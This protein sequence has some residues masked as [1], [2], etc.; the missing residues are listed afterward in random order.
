MASANT[1][2]LALLVADTDETQRYVFE[3]N[4][5]P[6]IRGASRLLFD[7]NQQCED[8]VTQ[9]SGEVIYAGGGSLL[10]LVPN[11]QG[12]QIAT[13]IEQLYPTQ[14][15]VATITAAVRPLPPSYQEKAFGQ[16]V[17]WATSWLTRRKES[18]SAPP[19]WAAMPFTV[20]CL[21]CMKRPTDPQYITDNFPDPICAICF[22]KREASQRNIWID[23]FES[24]LRALDHQN[25][26]ER[27]YGAQ[28]ANHIQSTYTLN[29]ISAANRARKGYVA[30][31][32][33]DGDRIGRQLRDLPRKAYRNFSRTLRQA[34]REAVFSALA[35]HLKPTQVPLS[36]L[37]P[38]SHN[39]KNSTAVVHPF[40]IITIGGDDVLLIVPADAGIPVATS[41]GQ[42]FRN[43]VAE[44][45][46]RNV[47]MSA[48]VILADD[49][50]PIRTMVDLAKQALQQA[51]KARHDVGGLDFHVLK[52]A[53]MLD[54][55]LGKMRQYPPYLQE[56][57][58][59]K[60]RVRLLGRPYDLDS[61]AE[62]WQGLGDLKKIGFANS[63]MHQ[64]SQV[65]LEGRAEATLYYAYQTA[66]DEKKGHYQLLTQ[67]LQ[68]LQATGET[69]PL[70]W[71]QVN[72]AYHGYQTA[73]WDIAELYPFHPAKQQN[74]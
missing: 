9:A 61:M 64:L 38:Q 60:Q 36:D 47:S 62:L 15:G 54:S 24:Y 10:A 42:K 3:S 6:E 53:D 49:H 43:I 18:K 19:F 70:P 30:L 25:L 8:L 14:T 52:S 68:K 16:Y 67:L 41:I 65:L 33:L 73:L 57:S 22:Q 72:N 44:Q 59:T 66:R 29:E 45:S 28:P 7:L 2:S 12:A 34:T 55:K 46:G 37:R 13:Q 35:T 11:T 21:S 71:E 1:A 58:S 4:K 63:Q 23:Q 27:Y 40:E 20:R 17:G 26:F 31:I 50:T 5:L 48:G 74:A 69:H 56:G 39:T 32:Y 51:K